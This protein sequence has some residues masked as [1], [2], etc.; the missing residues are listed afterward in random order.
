MALVR[1]GIAA[2]LGVVAGLY[3]P[4]MLGIASQWGTSGLALASS[5]AGWVEFLLLRRRLNQR[6][7]RTGIG[8]GFV[9]RLFG[10]A[11]LAA[12]AGY[13]ARLLVLDAHRFIVAAASLG[14]FGVV[15]FA[16]TYL[17]GVPEASALL[18]R[19]RRARN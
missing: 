3:A 1:V 17:F 12:G 11:V 13:G 10:A 5:V 14:A 16:L 7:G 15:Y 8:S 2:G 4:R 6:I 9:A 18:R 19:V